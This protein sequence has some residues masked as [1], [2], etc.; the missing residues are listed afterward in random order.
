MDSEI[1]KDWHIDVKDKEFTII[2]LFQEKMKGTKG[3]K[4]VQE[5]SI[6]HCKPEENDEI[7]CD[8]YH[9]SDSNAEIALNSAKE[10]DIKKIMKDEYYGEPGMNFKFGSSHVSVNLLRPETIDDAQGSLL[11][12]WITGHGKQENAT[13]SR[14]IKHQ[15][16]LHEMFT[17]E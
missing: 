1:L 8:H 16:K 12:E 14:L 5:I 4:C 3:V 11:S 2:Q 10:V 9:Y 17:W 7:S 13:V 6:L 15:G